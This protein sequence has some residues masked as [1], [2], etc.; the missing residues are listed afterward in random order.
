MDEKSKVVVACGDSLLVPQITQE[1]GV[2]VPIPQI[3]TDVAT[4]KCDW[5][6]MVA[7]AGDSET[8]AVPQIQT[9]EEIILEFTNKEVK[10]LVNSGIAT[11][12]EA[13]GEM[14]D[15]F[16]RGEIIM[17]G[18]EIL[19]AECTCDLGLHPCRLCCFLEAGWSIADPPEGL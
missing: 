18:C 9:T 10:G 6:V 11:A 14:R 12:V 2:A 16:K 19:A 8:A 5:C 13:V 4:C 1:V 7:N 3:Q 15:K 17:K